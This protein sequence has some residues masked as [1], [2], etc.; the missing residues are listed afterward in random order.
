MGLEGRV[1]VVTGGAQGIGAATAQRLAGDGARV[2][3]LD[4]DAARAVEVAQSLP[5]PGIGVGCDVTDRGQVEAAVART[6]AELGPVAIL[7]NNAGITRDN[8]LFRM[9]DDDWDLVI[10]THL[11]GAFLCTRS[12]QQHMVEQRY[13]R[14]VFLSSSSALGNAGQ[15]NYAAAKAGVQG[16]ARTVALELGKFGVTANAVAPGFVESAMTRSI[17]ER[18]GGSWED[19][20]AAAADRAA[21]RRTGKP[22][23]IAAVIAFLASEEAGFVTGQTIYATGSPAV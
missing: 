17:V 1:A 21:V 20:T 14:V 22:E 2:A 6:V 13:G 23:D 5:T 15:V 4:L 10:D 18:T 19:L 16:M 8:F 11:K 7:V 12:V 3:V 9:S